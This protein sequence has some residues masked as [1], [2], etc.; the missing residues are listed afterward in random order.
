M[1]AGSAVPLLGSIEE[2]TVVAWG[3]GHRATWERETEGAEDS[4]LV[5]VAVDGED[6]ELL[7][8]GTDESTIEA[9]GAGYHRLDVVPIAPETRRLPDLRGAFYGRRAFLRWPRSSSS[10]LA[11]YRIYADGGTGTVD[12]DDAVATVSQVEAAHLFNAPAESGTGD[13]RLSSRG[14]WSGGTVNRV[15]TAEIVSGGF[16]HD[17]SGS[18]SDAIEFAGGETVPIGSGLEITFED[19][20]DDYDTGDTWTI[21]V[22]PATSWLSGELVEG[23]HLF[24]VSAVDV[25]GN[26]SGLLAEESVVILHRPD[27]PSN[28]RVDM[29]STQV[30]IRWD[31]PD[32]D[33]IANVR[34]YANLSGMFG[35]LGERVLLDG[36]WATR[37]GDAVEYSGNLVSGLWKFL[38]RTVDSNGRE[39]DNVDIVEIDTREPQGVALNVPELVTVAPIAGGKFRLSWQYSR[40]GGESATRFTIYENAN[41]ASPSFETPAFTV[42]MPAGAGRLVQVSHDTADAYL[43]L[44][45]FTVRASTGAGGVETTNTD[46]TAGT[47][48]ATAPSLS[49]TIEG[50]PS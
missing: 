14:N 23:T 43:G 38:V 46:L 19:E 4:A 41:P 25:A 24:Q 35:S 20:V 2:L 22:G 3:G 42:A 18:W 34:I 10:D 36:A 15:V 21:A 47:P 8:T 32:D 39:S 44:T 33:D 7:P 9:A 1:I 13:G 48:D 17:V 27:A 11:G 30:R 16:R 37:P 29:V 50:L 12:T 49:G 45:Y 31:L 5:L 6:V 28:V 26:E 40:E